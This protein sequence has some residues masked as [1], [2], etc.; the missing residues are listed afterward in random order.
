MVTKF[1]F[2]ELWCKVSCQTRTLPYHKTFNSVSKIRF[3]FHNYY[4]TAARKQVE[5]GDAHVHICCSK[6]IGSIQFEVV[7]HLIS[8]FP[9]Y[10]IV[11]L[12]SK[13]INRIIYCQCRIVEIN[14][15]KYDVQ[16]MR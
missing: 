1:H 6:I 9:Y 4:C 2:L 5:V 12:G 3:A 15:L 16:K 14:N 8:T 13:R 7:P 11:W 10:F